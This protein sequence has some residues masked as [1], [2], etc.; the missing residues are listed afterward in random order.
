MKF[1]ITEGQVYSFKLNSGEEVVAKVV[2]I[3]GNFLEIEN[4]VSVAPNHQGM[5]LI[6]SLFTSD[7]QIPLRL[8]TNSVAVIGVTDDSVKTKYLEATTGIKIPDK[9]ILVG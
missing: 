7:P 5:G 8:N 4:P 2:A 9:K 1:T 3:D 6:P